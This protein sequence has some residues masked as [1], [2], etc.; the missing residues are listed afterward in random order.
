MRTSLVGALLGA[1]V[2][3]SGIPS[4]FIDGLEDSDYLISLAGKIADAA[5]QRNAENDQW[6]WPVEVDMDITIGSAAD[7]HAS[8]ALNDMLEPSTVDDMSEYGSEE[9]QQ[10]A[11]ILVLLGVFFGIMASFIA[12]KISGSSSPVERLEVP[13]QTTYDSI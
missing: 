2:G 5:L 6:Y 11:F 7:S 3:L 12:S 13:P 10:E 9:K 8:E 1:R 4:R